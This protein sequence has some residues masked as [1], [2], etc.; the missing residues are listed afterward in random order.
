M[1]E[2]KYD[3]AAAEC[4]N[5]EEDEHANSG[6]EIGC[7]SNRLAARSPATLKRFR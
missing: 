6:G 1:N 2:L 7:R 4:S 3:Y 5:F